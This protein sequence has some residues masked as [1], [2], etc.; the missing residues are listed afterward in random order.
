MLYCKNEMK[1]R[2]S[3][4]AGLAELTCPPQSVIVSEM[5]T[6]IAYAHGVIL[7]VWHGINKETEW[8]YWDDRKAALLD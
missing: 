2:R 5:S 7:R 6:A 4:S 3:I 8:E 1:P